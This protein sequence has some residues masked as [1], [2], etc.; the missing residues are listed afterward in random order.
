MN[1]YNDD[2][3]NYL[4]LAGTSVMPLIQYL[5]DHR[6]ID[7]I[8]LALDNDSAGRKCADKINETVQ[9]YETLKNRNISI[10]SEL[11]SEPYKDYNDVLLAVI[12]KQKET[13]L[14]R[15]KADISI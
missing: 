12:Q 4:S 11:P 3:Y 7:H 9:T 13:K 1:G 6:H 8:I 15:S 14:I 2:N 10:I 5:S